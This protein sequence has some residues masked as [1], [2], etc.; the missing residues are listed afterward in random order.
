MGL[1]GLI[2]G[3]LGLGQK[4]VQFIQ[5]GSSVLQLDASMKEVHSR[6]SEPTQ[7]PIETGQNISDHIIVRPFEIIITGII[8]DSP[9]G[10]TSGLIAE[11]A[12]TL[13]SAL[14]PPIGVIG[15]GALALAGSALFNIPNNSKS[16]PSI[17]A[18]N[19]LVGL[20]SNGQP[21]DVVTGLNTYKNMW[22]SNISIPRDSETSNILLFDVTLVQLILVKPQTVNITI[23]ANPAL[24]AGQTSVGEQGL[25]QNAFQK[26]AVAGTNDTNATLNAIKQ[27]VPGGLH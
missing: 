3:A 23:F 4:K 15:G 11:L 19:K 5:N 2:G 27:I 9:I 1:T 26:G 14:L 8:S 7:S 24:A 16:P 17:A 6:K 21:F 12:T 22:I 20:Q 18:Y 25:G 10:G 13:T